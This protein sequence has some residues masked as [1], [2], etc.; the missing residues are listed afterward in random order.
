[1]SQNGKRKYKPASDSRRGE[2]PAKK[3][4]HGMSTLTLWVPSDKAE[5]VR[6]YVSRVG[7]YRACLDVDNILERLRNYQ[8]LLQERFHVRKLSIFGSVARGQA[9]CHSDLDM[10]VEF[11]EGHPSG[12][13]A[14]VDLKNWLE[15]LL[16][17][18]VDLITDVNVKPRIRRRIMDECIEVF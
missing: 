3:G 9:M 14:F 8:K 16:D 12:L 17:R 4:R 10:L 18:P 7:R 13:F 11:E 2:K 15:G 6:R 1:M 5:A